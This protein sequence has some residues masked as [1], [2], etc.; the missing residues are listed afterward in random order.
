VGA[1]GKWR[2]RLQMRVF[3]SIPRKYLFCL[4]MAILV[5]SL[6]AF[7]T[8]RE[9]RQMNRLKADR[10]RIKAVVSQIREQNRNLAEEIESMGTLEGLEKEARKLGLVEKGELL[11]IFKN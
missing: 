2:S 11:Y 9:I 10:D 4:G 5:A 3:V 1:K 8:A 7:V 6:L